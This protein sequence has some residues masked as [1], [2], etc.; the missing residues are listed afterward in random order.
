V[1]TN[2][3]NSHTEATLTL[4]FSLALVFKSTVSKKHVKQTF[5]LSCGTLIKFEIHAYAYILHCLGFAQT[6]SSY[7]R[8]D[9]YSAVY[10][11]QC[12]Q[13]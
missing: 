11:L 6:S 12:A 8:V 3:N 13:Y 4:I 5:F 9:L 10:R 2:R 1:G 7:T